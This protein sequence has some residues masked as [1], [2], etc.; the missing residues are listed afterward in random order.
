MWNYE[1]SLSTAQS[2]LYKA[3]RHG[4]VAEIKVSLNKYP[5][6][7]DDTRFSYMLLLM[8]LDRWHKSTSLLLIKNNCTVRYSFK[9]NRY[10]TPLYYAL[11]KDDMT[12]FGELYKRGASIY[13]TDVNSETPLE[14]IMQH[15]NP[16]FWNV[17]LKKIDFDSLNPNYQE[18][19][20]LFHA[21]CYRGDLQI[22]KKFIEKKFSV[23]SRSDFRTEEWSGATPLQFALKGAGPKNEIVKYLLQ[24]DVDFDVQDDQGN[25]LVLTALQ[26]SKDP[27]NL[28]RS[29][30]ISRLIRHRSISNK[31]LDVIY[32]EYIGR[33]KEFHNRVNRYRLSHFHLLC[34]LNWDEQLKYFYGAGDE[35]NDYFQEFN[36]TFQG[37]PPILDTNDWILSRN[38]QM[39]IIELLAKNGA[40]VNDKDSQDLTPIAATCHLPERTACTT[41]NYIIERK[42]GILEE[43]TIRRTMIVQKLVRYGAD[44]NSRER[45]GKPVFHTLFDQSSESVLEKN[46]AETLLKEGANVDIADSEGLTLLHYV[47]ENLT[48]DVAFMYLRKDSLFIDLFLSFGA[49]VNSKS[50]KGDSILHTSVKYHRSGV[51]CREDLF[52]K[53]LEQSGVD[54]GVKNSIGD[55][56][57][58]SAAKECQPFCV[59]SL[60]AAGANVNIENAQGHTPVTILQKIL[61]DRNYEL[62]KNEYSVY[63]IIVAHLKKLIKLDRPVSRKNKNC[64]DALHE[65]SDSAI[66]VE[67]ENEMKKLR[68]MK[69]NQYTSLFKILVGNPE[70]MTNY[71]KN[72]DLM[73]LMSS[74]EQDTEEK[75]VDKVFKAYIRRF[76]PEKAC[77][78]SNRDGI[79]I[80]HLLCSLNWEN[81][82]ENYSTK[83]LKI[84][85][86][87]LNKNINVN[88]SNRLKSGHDYAGYTALHFATCANSLKIVKLLLKYGADPSKCDAKGNTALHRLD[89]T[90]TNCGEILELLL[91]HGASID[92]KNLENET[93]IHCAFYWQ[94][95][96]KSFMNLILNASREVCN[97]TNSEGLSLL[98]I[99]STLD[100]RKV[101]IFVENG[102]LVK[103]RVTSG[104]DDE[105]RDGTTPLH[106]ACSEQLKYFYGAPDE[107]NDLFAPSNK[108]IKLSELVEENED[109]DWALTRNKQIRIVELLL[110]HGASVN[111]KNS[112][113]LCPLIVAIQTPSNWNPYDHDEQFQMSVLNEICIRQTVIVDL[114]LNYGA[115]VDAQGHCKESLLHLLLKQSHQ[116]PLVKILAENILRKGAN[117]DA[118]DFR[119]YSPLHI[120][121]QEST[122]RINEKV[123][124]RID[125]SFID[126]FLTYGA[127]VNTRSENEDAPLHTAV[128]NYHS[129]AD[130][131]KIFVK[132]LE[133][134]RININARNNIG[135]TPLHLAVRK[136]HSFCVKILLN[137]GANINIENNDG[138]SPICIIYKVMKVPPRHSGT[139]FVLLFKTVMD[140]VK[141][142][143][144][145]GHFVSKKVTTSYQS[146]MKYQPIET[147]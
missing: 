47:V 95:R 98:H 76:N 81:E 146:L 45:H 108:I 103:A 92:A 143:M 19:I 77:N 41:P 96:N 93:P 78:L 85:T 119:G 68:S 22:A 55:T 132:L 11:K 80:F 90:D 30:L 105:T 1:C 38:K 84:I 106:L 52:V 4:T 13:D 62:R 117:V 144:A 73:E 129:D 86:F 59:K 26:I 24:F 54:L 123:Y 126:L 7:T 15:Q 125:T 124:H 114:L 5:N 51:E 110:K 67:I 128:K 111:T 70:D 107:Y 69:I 71:V 135:D 142:L 40:S 89:Y 109:F 57:L 64:L 42:D 66:D 139:I 75:F 34:S 44:V 122:Y 134:P 9:T 33:S 2:N 72:K 121:V 17:V 20:D 8:S 43:I 118:L 94:K 48:K 116:S 145:L 120:A 56:P 79:S 83:L 138:L 21:A 27:S 28:E 10:K 104:V 50:K 36:A 25:T 99:A 127:N 29:P 58:H 46:V 18:H 140:H 136:Q 133:Q 82:Y 113:K 91:K 100:L 23:N 53:L 131:K 115:N 6:F 60:L 88:S 32:K 63:E 102:A 87:F 49:N 97:H 39:R 65:S 31:Y 112:K 137:A 61:E 37:N 14:L 3:V 74:D 130:R 12:I 16:K 35:N 141:N 101:K 147:Q